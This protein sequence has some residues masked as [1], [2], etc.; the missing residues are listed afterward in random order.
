LLEDGRLSAALI[1]F[2]PGNAIRVKTREPIATNKW[3]HVAMI[4]D[5][6]SR[7]TG[8]QLFIDGQLAPAE[9]VR[10]NLS[11][12]ITGGGGDNIAIGERFR[13]RG[14]KG[15]LIDEF[16]VFDRQ[17]LP[18]EV[19]H[20]HNGHS[21]TDAIHAVQADDGRLFEYYLASIDKEYQTQ[22]TMLRE[23]REAKAA[24]ED[25]LQ[26]IMVMR[27][28]PTPRQ[29]FFLNRGAYDA[30][31]DLV[32]PE[33]PAVFPPMPDNVPK[34]RLGLARWLTDERHPLTARVAV[35]RLWQILFGNGLVATPEDF[36][37]QGQSPTHPEL[38]DWLANDFVEHG[39]DIKR[40]MKQLV[41]SATYR[42]ASTVAKLHLSLDPENRLL[43]RSPSNRLAAEMLRDN[44]LAVSGLLVD[45]IGGPSARP[46]E[47]EVSFKPVGRDS[48]DGLYRRS[49]YT[50]W[51]RTGPA[52]AMMT[53]D[54]AKR[55]VCRV[56]RERTAS[57]LQAFVLLNDPQFVE[58]ARMMAERLLIEHGDDT[59]AALINLFRLLTSRQPSDF[60]Q[61]IMHDLYDQQ[62]AAFSAN[63]EN[64]AR[65]LKT[66]DKPFSDSIDATRLAAL[67]VVA[68][69]LFSFDECV[70]KH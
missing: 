47:V 70:M 1:H 20:L 54:A 46:Y 49:L 22:R 39:W 19:A 31:G 40:S 58:A 69:T 28:L 68:N 51:K 62:L 36:G 52:P 60:E 56:K 11:K 26:E 17:L 12:K 57:P 30:P 38:L 34:N 2:W 65:Y 43:S 16:Q 45:R 50:Y 18:L 42:Q 14:F 9:V 13:D 53:L 37:S 7:A 61:G 55:D 10:D 8:L 33:T 41:M 63:E 24:I 6:S 59:D 67:A 25:S 23:A 44:A 4:Y 15:G 48:G 35:N 32:F 64:V 27:E 5:G 21:L 29:T 3:L 66:G